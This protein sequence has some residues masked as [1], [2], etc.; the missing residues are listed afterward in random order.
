MARSTPSWTRARR[1]GVAAS[2][3]V[4]GDFA[5]ISIRSDLDSE[6][7]EA[8]PGF[9]A[10]LPK[11]RPSL[12][13]D[14]GGDSLAYL[15]LG[16]PS[17]SVDSLREQAAAEAPA[18]LSA[19]DRFEATLQRDG[20]ISL[21]E[22]LLPLLGSEVALSVEP[23]IDESAP[24]TPGTVVSSG[25]PYVS[26]IAAGVDETEARNRPGRPAGAADRGSGSR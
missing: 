15:G 19:F 1:Q 8:S 11:F 14:V 26:L 3:S 17:S 22:D 13:A 21:E 20:G 2:V 24:V 5:D 7:S 4:E 9:F 6:E 12:T 18:L 10:A 23:V 16:D 25:T